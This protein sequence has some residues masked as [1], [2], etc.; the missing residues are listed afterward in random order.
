MT[1]AQTITARIASLLAVSH[2]TPASADAST[3]ARTA[4]AFAASE[5]AIEALVLR[6][7]LP[8]AAVNNN[9]GDAPKRLRHDSWQTQVCGVVA[10]ARCVSTLCSCQWRRTLVP[11]AVPVLAFIAACGESGV[12][13]LRSAHTD[14]NAIAAAWLDLACLAAELHAD[15]HRTPPT[16]TNESQR[17]DTLNALLTRAVELPLPSDTLA[18]LADVHC[19]SVREWARL[20]ALTATHQRATFDV[21]VG[22]FLYCCDRAHSL[23]YYHSTSACQRHSGCAVDRN[24]ASWTAIRFRSSSEHHLVRINARRLFTSTRCPLSMLHIGCRR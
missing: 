13:A 11:L 23:L 17:A 18:A 19:R 2:V 21:L 9:D 15:A 24:M 3:A 22:A 16:T 5:A 10:R 14:I 8:V 1:S 6:R 7:L 20:L 4:A 12:R